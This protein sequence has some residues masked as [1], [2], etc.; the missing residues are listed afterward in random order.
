[1]TDLRLLVVLPPARI[2][3]HID[4]LRAMPHSELTVI[5][6]RSGWNV[7]REEVLPVRR[8]PVIGD[9][10]GW[11]AAVAWYRG[12]RRLDADVDAVLSIELY[13]VGSVQADRLARRLGVPHIIG[14][15]ENRPDNPLYRAPPW[16]Q[17]AAYNVPRAS[18]FM[19]FT[20]MAHRHALARGCPPERCRVVY[21]GVDTSQWRPPVDGRSSRPRVVFVGQLRADRG[22]DKGVADIVRAGDELA[23]QIEAFELVMVG[24][25]PLRPWL[26]E[27]AATRPHLRVPGPLPRAEVAELLQSARAFV[28]ASKRSFKWSEQFCFALVEAMASGLPVVAT[29]SGAIPDVVAPWNPLVPEG[30]SVALAA[31]LRQALGPAGEDWGNRNVDYARS[32]FD[33]RTQGRSL[34]AAFLDLIGSARSASDTRPPARSEGG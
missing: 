22:A 17:L 32:R 10:E 30:D 24:D 19:C 27:Q 1:M 29:R 9:P 18:G 16:R 11:A 5:S 15:S 21:P 14:T 33:V 31:A 20:E 13:S 25:G 7:R 4:M 12:L 8:V 34:E 28:M 6:D 26:E 2:S 3:H 23:D